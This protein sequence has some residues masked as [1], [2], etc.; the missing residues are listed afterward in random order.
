MA[1]ICLIPFFECFAYTNIDLFLEVKKMFFD[2]AKAY[3]MGG[4]KFPDIQGVVTFKDVRNGV[5]LTAKITGLP[6]S[7]DHCTGRFFGFHIHERNFLFW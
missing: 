3:I 5:L 4:R 6:Q 2:T 1:F 7:I